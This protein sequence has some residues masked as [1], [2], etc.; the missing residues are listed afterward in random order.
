MP[1]GTYF[2]AVDETGLSFFPYKVDD[3]IN[4]VDLIGDDYE[5]GDEKGWRDAVEKLRD[6]DTVCCTKHM[7]HG[8]A[9]LALAVDFGRRN[10]RRVVKAGLEITPGGFRVI[11]FTGE[12]V[13]QLSGEL[14]L[15]RVGW[16]N[17]PWDKPTQERFSD[18]VKYG[19]RSVSVTREVPESEWPT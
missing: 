10:D 4:W 3:R 9:D 16:G 14:L 11:E 12:P 2:K 13:A 19:F 8:Y 17:K 18:A 7:I 1:Q 6:G 15:E 5:L